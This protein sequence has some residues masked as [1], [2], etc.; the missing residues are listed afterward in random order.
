MATANITNQN[1]LHCVAAQ[2]DFAKLGGA[3][4]AYGLG[5]RIP[6]GSVICNAFARVLTAG[7]SADDTATIAV[8][9]EAANDI[10]T[11]AAVSG[12]PWSTTGAKAGIPDLATVGDYKITTVER[13]VTVTIAV[14][15]LTAGKFDIFIFYVNNNVG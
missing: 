15:A 6:A 1:A 5:V 7:D 13:E 14:Q 10:I 4:G 3:V 2:F 9:V 8:H 12:A 11:A